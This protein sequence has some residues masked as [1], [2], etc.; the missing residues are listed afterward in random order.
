LLK[1]VEKFGLERFIFV[2]YHQ[3]LS[4]EKLPLLSNA[5]EIKL[6]NS[7][8]SKDLNRTISSIHVKRETKIIYDKLSQLSNY[9]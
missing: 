5:L 4:G 2:H 3:L 8:I 1:N 6:S 7:F 9:K